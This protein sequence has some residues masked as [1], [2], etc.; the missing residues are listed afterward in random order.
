MLEGLDKFDAAVGAWFGAVEKASQEAAAGLAKRIFD[1][2]LIESPQATADFV[3]NW[4]V[5]VNAPAPASDFTAGVIPGKFK[6]YPDSVGIYST[7]L[8]KRGDPEGINYAKR[9]VVWSPIK[10]GDIIFISNSAIHDEAYAWLIEEGE[11]NFR[12]VNAG[13]DYVGYRSVQFV[14]NRYPNIGSA[15]LAVLRRVGV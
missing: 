8:F 1:K 7:E 11:V 2:V 10:L 9:H 6:S 3:A 5:S 15:Q 4:K 13:A 14:A 12:Q